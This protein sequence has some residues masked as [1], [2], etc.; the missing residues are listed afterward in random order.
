MGLGIPSL[1]NNML[2]SSPLKSTMLVG[3][4]AV[5]VRRMSSNIVGFLFTIVK[6]IVCCLLSVET[7]SCEPETCVH[8]IIHTIL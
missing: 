1:K 7:P 3:G 8:A 6:H 2:E 5:Q 4:L